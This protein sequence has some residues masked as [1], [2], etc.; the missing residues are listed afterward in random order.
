LDLTRLRDEA[1][2][3]L[4]GACADLDGLDLD[5][6]AGLDDLDELGTCCSGVSGVMLAIWEEGLG[7]LRLLD[8]FE[9]TVDTWVPV[10]SDF[11]NW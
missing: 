9:V 7:V 10:G 1:C 6:C 3:D 2:A 11:A 8:P 5:E 4:D